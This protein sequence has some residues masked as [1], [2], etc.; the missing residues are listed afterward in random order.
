RRQ[1]ED[2]FRTHQIPQAVIALKQGVGRLIRGEDDRGVIVIGDPRVLQQSYGR[3]FLESLPP[4]PITR[5]IDD[6]RAFFAERPR[7]A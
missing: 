5:S 2:P 1:G 7:S 3:V 4:L 6:V